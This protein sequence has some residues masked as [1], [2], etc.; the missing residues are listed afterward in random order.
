M[1]AR[2]V[3]EEH[4]VKTILQ[5][6]VMDVAHRGKK[7]KRKRA[8]TGEARDANIAKWKCEVQKRK[9][10]NAKFKLY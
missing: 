10:R 7:R 5:R 4:A 9:C 8:K 1:T 6:M 3:Y 2:Q